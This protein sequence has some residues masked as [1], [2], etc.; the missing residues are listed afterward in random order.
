MNKAR[1][2]NCLSEKIF[3]RVGASVQLAA[4]RPSGPPLSQMLYLSAQ[5]SVGEAAT[6]DFSVI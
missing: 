4:G 5:V 2:I 6:A 1:K 3:G